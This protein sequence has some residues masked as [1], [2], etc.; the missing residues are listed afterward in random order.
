MQH[1]TVGG[2]Q[3]AFD[4]LCYWCQDASST[5]FAAQHNKGASPS[6]VESTKSNLKE[7]RYVRQRRGRRRV[8]GWR[9][10]KMGRTPR[11]GG[12]MVKDEELVELIH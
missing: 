10:V 4:H 2:G 8:T 5:V 9:T 7:A 1:I 6:L 11:S 12:K 3:G